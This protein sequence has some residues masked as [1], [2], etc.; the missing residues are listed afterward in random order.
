MELSKKIKFGL[1]ETRMLILGSQILLG[2]QLREVFA[3]AFDELPAVS[4]HASAAGLALLT[5]TVGLLIAPGP[6][7]RMVYGGRDDPRLQPVITAFAAASL[8]PFALAL[9]IDLF[10]S[11]ERVFGVSAGFAVG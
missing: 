10:L 9:G 7:H 5:A 4:R 1:D 8:A 2:F 11:L 6:Y 3:E